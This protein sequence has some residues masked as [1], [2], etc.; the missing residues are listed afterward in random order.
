MNAQ[1]ARSRRLPTGRRGN[2]P[3]GSLRIVS[4]LAANTNSIICDGSREP[5]TANGCP[6]LHRMRGPSAVR[7]SCATLNPDPS[8]ARSRERA[9]RPCVFFL[10]L[11]YMDVGKPHQWSGSPWLGLDTDA[12]VHG[13]A[14]PPLAAEIAFSCLHGNVPEKELDLVQF[15]TRSMAQLGAR[16]PQ[17]MRCYLGKLEFSRVLLHD[18]PD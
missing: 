5:E 15:S 4:G 1:A 3:G 10:T 14:N 9:Q 7:H 6:V 17:I 18:M 11:T 13:S 8:N 16:T 2:T 12:V